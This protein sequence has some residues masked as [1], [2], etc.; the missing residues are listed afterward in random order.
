MLTKA[1]TKLQSAYEEVRLLQTQD[2]P[3]TPNPLSFALKAVC[4][5]GGWD[6]GEAWIPS[7]DGS[8]LELSPDSWYIPTYVDS[9]TVTDLEMF[10]LCSEGFVM[11]PN[12]GL[13]GRVWLSGT[14][15]LVP[16]VSAQSED[17]FLRNKIAL[18]Y[19][20]KTGFGIPIRI[21][22][23]VQAVLVFFRTI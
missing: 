16:N 2:L 22:C 1:G 18:A 5:F 7:L 23:K 10:R 21:D 20:V 13:P 12:I 15:E 6:Y 11:P 19:G 4:E 17:Y 3:N 9:A 14:P 8:V